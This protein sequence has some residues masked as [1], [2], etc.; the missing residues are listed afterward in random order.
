M[1]LL[2]NTTKGKHLTGLSDQLQKLSFSE[3]TGQPKED[4]AH[5]IFR[6]HHSIF[7]A[8]MANHCNIFPWNCS[9][10]LICSLSTRLY[11]ARKKN[12]KVNLYHLLLLENKWKP[13]CYK[14]FPFPLPGES[15]SIYNI[16]FITYLQV[17][18]RDNHSGHLGLTQCYYIEIHIIFF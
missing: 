6:A 11:E 12:H 10:F 7:R 4:N 9:D 1:L 14:D 17:F 2:E 15:D 8:F 16:H 5:N 18:H 13:L 3:S